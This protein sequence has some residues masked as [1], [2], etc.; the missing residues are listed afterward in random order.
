MGGLAFSSVANAHRNRDVHVLVSQ[1]ISRFF[2]P[3]AVLKCLEIIKDSVRVRFC[4]FFWVCFFRFYV[5]TFPFFYHTVSRLSQCSCSF[6]CCRVQ[7]FSIF[8]V[9]CYGV[10]VGKTTMT[11]MPPAAVIL[12]DCFRFRVIA[13]NRSSQYPP[14]T[15]MPA[16]GVMNMYTM[17]LARFLKPAYCRLRRL[18]PVV[19]RSFIRCRR[20]FN[21][22]V[23]AIDYC[24]SL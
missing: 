22:L 8:P 24:C 16:Q 2:S 23:W 6:H 21:L 19:K 4:L 12:K 1:I 18:A 17:L 3:R 11:S 15:T 10:P 14:L 13:V 20:W 7:F 5:V 9:G